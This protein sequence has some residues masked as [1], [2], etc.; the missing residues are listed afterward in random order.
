LKHF[1]YV[2]AL[3]LALLGPEFGAGPPTD[4]FDVPLKKE[5]VDLGPSQF[6]RYRKKLLCY[7]Y[8]TLMVKVYGEEWEKGT[9]WLAILPIKEG[10][11]TP[12]CDQA[13]APGE[14]VIEAKEWSGPLEGVKGNLV[15]FSEADGKDGGMPFVVYDA[16]MGKKVFED[17]AYDSEFVR[18]G[19]GVG[20]FSR[21]R[22]QR[23]ADGQVWLR[24]LR[25]VAFDC[26]LYREKAACWEQVRKKLDLDSTR[27]PVCGGYKGLPTRWPSA[28]AYPVEVNLFRQPTIK[29][30]PGPVR[31][32]PVD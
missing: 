18:M 9:E 22:I 17:T 7:F 13:H 19:I 28:V 27:M 29:T 21:L 32:W 6:R 25:V 4:A 30:I 12:V 5:L 20:P 1:G 14:R 3:V 26:D 15:F 10:G 11:A 23:T 16:S 8:P 2:A 31:C 24:Y